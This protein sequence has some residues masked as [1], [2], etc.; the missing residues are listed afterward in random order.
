M[1]EFE[2]GS[3]RVVAGLVREEGLE[4]KKLLG[5]LSEEKRSAAYIGG[6]IMRAVEMVD[7]FINFF[8]CTFIYPTNHTAVTYFGQ[9]ASHNVYGCTMA[10][11]NSISSIKW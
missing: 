4:M 7:E 3:R 1:K 2:G 10:T 5:L 9:Q 6:L 8:M 11:V